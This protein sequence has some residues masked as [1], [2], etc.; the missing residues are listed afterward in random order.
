MLLGMR[1]GL[2][3]GGGDVNDWFLVTGVWDSA[4]VWIDSLPYVSVFFLASGSWSAVGFWID[5]EVYP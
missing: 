1:S 5:D 3:G 4:G 2:S